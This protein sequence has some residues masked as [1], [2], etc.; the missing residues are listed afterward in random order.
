MLFLAHIKNFLI[1]II[2]LHKNEFCQY[3]EI[4]DLWIKKRLNY[5]FKRCICKSILKLKR[6]RFFKEK[7]KINFIQVIIVKHIYCFFFDDDVNILNNRFI[8]LTSEI[9]QK[10]TIT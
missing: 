2:F 1:V 3:E 4:L 7:R 10:F 8:N 6:G 9:D 5:L